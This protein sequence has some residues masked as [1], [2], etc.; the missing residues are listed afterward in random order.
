MAP[1]S[2]SDTALRARSVSPAV[3]ALLDRPRPVAARVLGAGYLAVG[4]RVV[5]VEPAGAPRMPNGI[6][7]DLRAEPDEAVWIGAG[8]LRTGAVAVTAGPVWDPRPHARARLGTGVRA[9]PDALALA[10]HGPGLTPYGDDVLAGFAAGLVLWHDEHERAAALAEAAAPR[11]TLLSATLLRHA[12]RGELPE[13][14]HALL[15]HGDPAPLCRFG[16][17]SGRGIMLGLALAC[18]AAPEGPIAVRAPPLP[19]LGDAEPTVWV[20]PPGAP[21]AGGARTAPARG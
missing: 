19:A 9:V 5:A 16:S 13:P 4:E 10:G 18:G 7:C 12:A 14:A 8:R 1:L 21:A 15:E 11:T 2:A 6:A 20:T 17:S 3:L